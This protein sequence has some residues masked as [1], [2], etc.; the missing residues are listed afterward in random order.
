MTFGV[1][2][3]PPEQQRKPKPSAKPPKPKN[4]D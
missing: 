1:P 2:P 4:K 3:K